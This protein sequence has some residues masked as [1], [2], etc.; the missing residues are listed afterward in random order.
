[1]RDEDDVFVLEQ[2]FEAEKKRR[3]HGGRRRP[4]GPQPL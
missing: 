2:T 1:V 4:P 3:G